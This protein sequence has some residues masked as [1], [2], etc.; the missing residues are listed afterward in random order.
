M[1]TAKEF[2]NSRAIK[3]QLKRAIKH[4]KQYFEDAIIELMEMYAQEQVKNIA[5]E[6]VLAPVL[7]KWDCDDCKHYPCAHQQMM[8][9]LNAKLR[10]DTC[11][12]HSERGTF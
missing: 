9:D 2:Y 1:M 4:D 12:D 7:P 5:Y 3:H 11:G 8:N 6:P 10:Y